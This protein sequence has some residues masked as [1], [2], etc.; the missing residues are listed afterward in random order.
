[1]GESTGMI[2][3]N[4]RVT[5]VKILEAIL[6]AMEGKDLCWYQWWENNLRNPRWEGFKIMVI[7]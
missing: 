5:K 4:K 7:K 2:F 3:S 6:V 1:M